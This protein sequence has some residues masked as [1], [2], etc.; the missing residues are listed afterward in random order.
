MA[1]SSSVLVEKKHGC[2]WIVLPDSIDMYNYQQIEER[3]I[4]ELEKNPSHIVLDF[5]ATKALFSSGIGLVVRLKKRASELKQTI[6]LVNIQEKIREGL[7]NVGLETAFEI[8]KNENDF[9]KARKKA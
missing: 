2:L 9:L 3:I 8:Y 5:S 7:E 6:S 4:P 1:K